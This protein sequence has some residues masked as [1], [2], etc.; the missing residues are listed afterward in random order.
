MSIGQRLEEDELNEA[1]VPQLYSALGEGD[2]PELYAKTYKLDTGHD[3]PDGGGNSLD[4]KTIFIDRTLYEEVMDGEFKKTGLEPRQII[5]L[6]CDHEH[7]EKC[8]ADGNNAVDYYTPCHKRGLRK[9]H[10]GVDLI[11]GPGKI[12]LYESTTWPGFVRCYNKPIVK[13]P[14][15]LWCDPYF[16]DP[17]ERDEEILETLQKLGVIDAMKTGK[18]AARYGYVVHACETCRFYSPDILSQQGG[19]LAMCKV[20]SGLVQAERGCDYWQEV[21]L[22]TPKEK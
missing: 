10:Q 19:T 2:T 5:R 12:K 17:T 15:D 20:V 3:I 4:R 7:S 18:H 22:G 16:D 9:E 14:K 13:P 8:I 11:L 6:W 1:T 21:T